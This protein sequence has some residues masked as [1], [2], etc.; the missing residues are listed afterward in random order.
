MTDEALMA[1]YQKGDLAAFGELVARHEKRLWNFLRRFVRDKATAED[2]LQ[3]VFLRVVKS[4][5][6][7]QPSAKVSTWLFTIARNLCTDQARRA[8][9][10]QAES[11]DQTKTG[12]EGSG[13]RRIDRIAANSDDAEKAAMGHEIASLVDRAV[14]ELPV[15]Q[16]EVFLMREVM[17][18]SFAEIAAQVG[19]SEPTV[20]S[21]MRYALQRL[22]AS[23]GELHE[24]TAA[25][26]A[27]S[28][29]GTP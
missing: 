9:F 24:S 14:A 27:V 28:V 1:A 22:R 20:K 5:A 18:M 19:A 10:R 7:W 2:L 29:E 4:A 16:R 17:D 26:A 8:E 12:E 13:L 11:L 6:D 15:D 21:R 23:L 3:E 25:G